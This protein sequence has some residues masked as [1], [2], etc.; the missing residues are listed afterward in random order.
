M[1]KYDFLLLKIFKKTY[2]AIILP[3]QYYERMIDIYRDEE[4]YK[5]ANY[6][7]SENHLRYFIAFTKWRKLHLDLQRTASPTATARTV[8]IR[9]RTDMGAISFVELTG[10]VIVIV[11]FPLGQIAV[12]IDV[13]V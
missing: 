4:K 1:Q 9:D 12:I 7:A 13:V 11:G 2:T 3:T 5:S 10:V 8:S 6:K